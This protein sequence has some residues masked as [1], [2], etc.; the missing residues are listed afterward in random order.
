MATVDFA[1]LT[2]PTITG[3]PLTNFPV[4]LKTADF[5]SASISGAAGSIANGGGNFRAYTASDKVTQL[6][7][8]VVRFVTGG[9]PDIEVHVKVPSA[10]TGGT[11][12][13][14]TDDAVTN[15]PAVGAA[16]GRQSVWTDY[17]LVSHD[18]GV[19]DSATAATLIDD[20]SGS[21]VV[22]TSPWGAALTSGA[23]RYSDATIGDFTT[24]FV[25]QA[26]HN[27]NAVN[28]IVSRKD[29]AQGPW[30]LY[31][32]TGLNYWSTTT[33][34]IGAIITAAASGWHSISYVVNTAADID[35]WVDGV[36]VVTAINKV[37]IASD[38]L[39][40]T[41]VGHRGN[42]G[43]GT[44]G[45]HTN[46]EIIGEVRMKSGVLSPDWL[47]A[48]FS[49][50]NA[51]VAWVTVGAWSAGI[52][53]KGLQIVWQDSSETLQAN[54][55]GIEVA[56]FDQPLP[57]NFLAPVFTTSTGTTN[58]SGVFE[59]DID[60]VTALAIGATGFLIA[61]DID[62]ADHRNTQFIVGQFNVQDIG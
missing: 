8:D 45:G 59:I 15:Q 47:T 54:L 38:P 34:A 58:A 41:R 10:A 5:P 26:W 35:F 51:T 32:G 27:G 6:S 30:S 12:Y 11:I 50:Q 13:I 49:N 17:A 25:V 48:E 2:L 29:T 1:T 40:P 52:V 36:A 55:T 44:L 61:Y 22:S 21:S 28:T 56:F 42:G 3:G 16:F 14:E 20:N 53:T 18:G 46:G 31:T 39:M 24:D 23:Q 33:G 4:L 43:I 62:G 19:T 57:G 7:L 60:A 9:S 37:S